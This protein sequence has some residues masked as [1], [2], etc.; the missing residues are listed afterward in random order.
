MITIVKFNN[1]TSIIHFN[2]IFWKLNL[3]N[4]AVSLKGCQ[5]LAKNS[6]LVSQWA[7]KWGCWRKRVRVKLR[8]MKREKYMKSTKSDLSCYHALYFSLLSFWYN[9]VSIVT[10]RL[11]TKRQKEGRN[12]YDQVNWKHKGRNAI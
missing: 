6:E 5:W 4:T 12:E 1:L 11:W 2:C 3:A 8:K 10:H 9:H 7:I